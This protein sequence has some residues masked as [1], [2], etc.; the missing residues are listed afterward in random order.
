MNAS[1]QEVMAAGARLAP[2]YLRIDQFPVDVKLKLVVVPVQDYPVFP[3]GFDLVRQKFVRARQ[4]G[5]IKHQGAVVPDHERPL[6]LVNFPFAGDS[7][8][9]GT[10][11]L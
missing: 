11:G 3:V 4:S 8:E 5:L 6:V 7:H 10:G 1:D 2:E 9:S